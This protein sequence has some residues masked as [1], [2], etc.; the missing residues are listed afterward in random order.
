MN[1]R[2][3]WA[4]LVSLMLMAT[5]LAVALCLAGLAG[6]EMRGI[7]HACQRTRLREGAE[8]AARRGLAEL[9]V[10][11]GPDA[12]TTFKSSDKILRAL[13]GEA[14][15]VDLQ[16]GWAE[17]DL[18][19]SWEVE[20]LSQSF[21]LASRHEARGRASTWAKSS[22][23]R[24]RL[25]LAL[26]EEALTP[27]QQVALQVGDE[28]MFREAAI[29]PLSAGLSFQSKTL[30]TDPVRGGW[31]KDL[32]DISVMSAELGPPLTALLNRRELGA[33]ARQG[34]PMLRCAESG[35]LWSH[36]PMLVDFRLSMGF[37]NSRSD[38]R[39]RLRFHGGGM[40][41]NPSSVPAL[42]GPL[43]R[44]FLVELDGCP[45]V[46]VKNLDTGSGFT[47]N[48]DDCPQQDFGFIRQ[49]PREKGLWC[50]MDVAE[51]DTC[52]M[53]G[54]GLLAGEAYA[55]LNPLPET[56]PQGLSRI[57]TDE[58]WRME[59]QPHGSTWQRPSP[60]VFLPR[61]RIEITVRFREK[62]TLRLRPALGDP[63][64]ESLIADYPSAPVITFENISFPDF[65][66]NT[67][68]ED[69]SREDSSGYVIDERR[70]CLRFKLRPRSMTQLWSD[71]LA[72]AQRNH[73]DFDNP[74]DAAEWVVD[75]PL[76]AAL[77]VSDFD[78]MPLMGALWDAIPNRHEARKLGAFSGVRLRELPIRPLISPGVLRRLE[79]NGGR[80]WVERLDQ[81]YASAPLL[82]PEA[83]V[84]SHHPWLFPGPTP[85]VMGAFNVNS[86]NPDAW[87]AFL[88]AAAGK[89]TA[90]G[91]GPFAAGVLTGP[92]F[93]TQPGGA[94]CAKWGVRVQMD[95]ADAELASLG[96]DDRDALASQ[97]GVRQ[98]SPEIVRR[99]AEK[100]VELQVT[101]GYPFRSLA[102]FTHSQI[103]DHALVAVG[104]NE[105]VSHASGNAPVI[106]NADDLLEAWAPLLT[107]RG[108]TF[109]IRGRAESSRGGVW[110]CEYVVQRV[111]TEHAVSACGRR[112]M[113]ISARIRNQ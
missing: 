89:W 6:V 42:A 102:S 101:H 70:A 44:M 31:R 22:T 28:V 63:S 85:M 103:L 99:L 88:G 108:D 112:F 92:I 105:A 21:D 111:P 30:L 25:P 77:D 110:V 41:W 93:F 18:R 76:L 84:S 65:T 50:W 20:D 27:W 107:V 68:G 104:I 47:V 38:G 19:W 54:R 32:A 78:R 49:G 23:G 11:A 16:G 59:T 2:N 83:G 72:L 74:A 61:D 12:V 75:H 7:S 13:R 94:G 39:H 79:T 45:E 36:L 109:K 14:T 53:A 96:F 51:P 95:L 100:I 35:R 98:V 5:L 55:F 48:L 113:I 73:W 4:L 10:A 26:P 81:F 9:Q 64:K 58:T 87:A 91:G 67:I 80:G 66:I 90:D 71:G 29:P 17:D 3:G 34:F 60:A 46:T 82:T 57:L 1:H 52:G 56:Q 86:R 33:E 106:I 37:F 62:L 69:Y 40:V 24:Q 97:Q 15:A 8:Q 43:G